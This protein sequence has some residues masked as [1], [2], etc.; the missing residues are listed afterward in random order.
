MKICCLTLLGLA[1]AHKI[2]VVDDDLDSLVIP[3]K[4]LK[5]DGFY[6][7]TFTLRNF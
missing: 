6:A 2:L 3:S 4:I 5:D 1:M 7:Q